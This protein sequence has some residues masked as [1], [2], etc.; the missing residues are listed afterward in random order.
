VHSPTLNFYMNKVNFQRFRDSKINLSPLKYKLGLSKVIFVGHTINK[1]GL[2]FKKSK[3]VLFLN[4]SRP[5]TKKLVKSF[6]G[7]AILFRDHIKNHST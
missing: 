2:H 6:L 7:L 1:D 5:E 4:F 3:L